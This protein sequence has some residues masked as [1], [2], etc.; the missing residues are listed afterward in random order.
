MKVEVEPD[1]V[2]TYSADSR[3]R[4]TLGS[5]FSDESVEVAILDVQDSD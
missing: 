4:I 1:D 3:G 5:D 2:D